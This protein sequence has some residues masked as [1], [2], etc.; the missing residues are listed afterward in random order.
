[1]TFEAY[2]QCMPGRPEVLVIGAGV[3][4]LTTAL[5]LARA[6][7][8][9]RIHTRELPADTTSC[10]AGASWGPYMATDQR[11]LRWSG[12]TR[13][14]LV[15]LAAVP[16][17]GVRLVCGLEASRHRVPVPA[18]APP[19]PGF[20]PAT[21]DDLPDGF[22]GGWWYVA[23]VVEMPRYLAYLVKELDALGVRLEIRRVASLTAAAQEAAVVVNCTGV[24]ARELVPDDG[25]VPSRGQL[26]VVENPGVDWFFAEYDEQPEPTYFLPHGDTIVLG[27]SVEPGRTDLAPDLAASDAIRRRCAVVEPKLGSARVVAHRVGLRPTRH[28]IRVEREGAVVHNYGHGGAGVTVSWGCAEEVVRLVAGT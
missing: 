19:L 17:S 6:G 22:V 21:A 24:G 27:G 14:E 20:R 23:P 5:C 9:V 18:W 7:H 8:P 10:A 3:S 1:M 15:E 2:C 25:L 12:Q 11:V 28:R 26:V 16:G 4:G 13:P